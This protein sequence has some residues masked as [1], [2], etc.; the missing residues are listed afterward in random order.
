[1][2]KLVVILS[3]CLAFVACKK[4]MDTDKKVIV[5]QQT[6]NHWQRIWNDVHITLLS[7]NF[8]GRDTGYVLTYNDSINGQY[9]LIT[10]DRGKTWT[11]KVVNKEP[12]TKFFVEIL[13]LGNFLYAQY[14]QIAKPPKVL[15]RHLIKSIDGGANWSPVDVK[16][17][18]YHLWFPVDSL[19][20]YVNVINDAF[21]S[22]NMF[23]THDGGITW[24]I[25]HLDRFN[26]V[27]GINFLSE[28]IGFMLFS[29]YNNNCYYIK[30]TTDG[31]Q[32]WLKL[33]SKIVFLNP[34]DDINIQFTS[35]NTWYLNQN[36][37]LLLKTIDGGMSWENIHKFKMI[38][39]SSGNIYI[40]NSRFYFPIKGKRLHFINTDTGFYYDDKNIYM[41][42][43][44]GK[45]WNT[46][47]TLT[48]KPVYAKIVGMETVKSGEVY[49]ITDCG[50]IFKR[51]L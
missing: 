29:D 14:V 49:I 13:P 19:N 46:D 31:G 28:N 9:L 18:Y 39:R 42:G 27:N 38:P 22:S 33:E 48:G 34:N 4:N 41:S 5:D 17:N 3:A 44:A 2:R 36:D 12:G 15:A 47:F 45:T 16:T 43:D 6:N 11:N 40:F 24:Q 10:Y 20:I 23:S 8:S 50:A 21:D 51:E 25:F 1:M 37:T 26:Y 35:E 32:T 7:V 30:K